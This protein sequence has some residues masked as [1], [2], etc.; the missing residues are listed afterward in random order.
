M[1]SMVESWKTMNGATASARAR[2]V[3]QARNAFESGDRSAGSTLTVAWRPFGP[4]VS[5]TATGRADAGTRPS[6]N[7]DR[8]RR[9]PRPEAAVR[10][11]AQE[12]HRDRLAPGLPAEASV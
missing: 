8:L 1:A 3:R 6:R 4:V 10:V 2:A 5:A 9:P 7:R 11:V 12:S